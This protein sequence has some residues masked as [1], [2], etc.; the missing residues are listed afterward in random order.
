MSDRDVGAA[1]L[2]ERADDIRAVMAAAGSEKAAIF[3][4]SEGGSMT[5]M[6]AACYP[7]KVTSIVMIGSFPC[8]AW[9]PDW[10]RGQRRDEFERYI[11]D[12]ETNWGDLGHLLSWAAPSVQDDP[13]ERAFF[14]R[15]L[16]QSASPA[17]AVALTRL[18]YEI[19]YR[20]ILPAINVPALI[21]HPER[22]IAVSVEDGRY[23]AEHIPNARFE[24]VK[25]SDH[26][27]WIGDSTELVKQIA[28]FVHN[29]PEQH[30]ED[31]VLA[32][33]LMTDIVQSTAAAEMGDAQWRETM[34]AH[35][36]AAARSVAR[37][38]GRLI[39]TMGDGMLATFDGPSR[40]IACAGAIQV[41]AEK[42][43]LKVRAGVHTGECLRSGKM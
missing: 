37:H 20:S 16:M 35:D 15:L 21:L 42:L 9:K 4:I 5:A 31:R 27:P 24:F 32:T 1:T 19:D 17:S 8:R 39:K 29:A 18:N 23:L 26:L 10:P 36:A 40:A 13:D 7:E 25:N 14:N 2:E 33:I 3:G 22:D 12:I 11:A 41:A 43:G 34:E 6:F 38:G 30:R 28:D